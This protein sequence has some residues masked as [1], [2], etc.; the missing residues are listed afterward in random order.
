[1]LRCSFHIMIRDYCKCLTSLNKNDKISICY[2]FDCENLFSFLSLFLLVI[3]TEQFHRSQRILCKQHNIY[4]AERRIHTEIT[5]S[6]DTHHFSF[7]R[8]D[9]FTVV[10]AA[11]AATATTTAPRWC[12]VYNAVHYIMYEYF[13]GMNMCHSVLR[14]EMEHTHFCVTLL[15]SI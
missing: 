15:Q 8:F 6:I 14:R 10:A 1:M 3:P 4:D 2:V 5:A 13:A 7:R 9:T 11:T 12:I